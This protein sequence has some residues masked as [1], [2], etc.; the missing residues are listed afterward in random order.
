[1][2]RADDERTVDEAIRLGFFPVESTLDPDG[3]AQ[4]G[5]EHTCA[6]HGEP[7]GRCP[8]C[9]GYQGDDGPEGGGRP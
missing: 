8:T 9:D 3:T 2:T 6:A 5:Q 7:L 1:V 4:T